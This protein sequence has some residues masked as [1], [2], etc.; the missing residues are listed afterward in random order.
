M[1]VVSETVAHM[2]EHV[3]AEATLLM[4]ESQSDGGQDRADY[5]V[6]AIDIFTDDDRDIEIDAFLKELALSGLPGPLRGAWRRMLLNA[7]DD[8]RPRLVIQNWIGDE[9]E[10]RGENG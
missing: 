8:P 3:L 2:L 7:E 6:D 4:D 10:V 9:S 5:A 1:V